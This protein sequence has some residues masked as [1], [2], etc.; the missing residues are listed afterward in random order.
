[1]AKV[2]QHDWLWI[3]SD[4]ILLLADGWSI[5]IYLKYIA[6]SLRNT[7]E[8]I[9][10]S[11]KTCLFYWSKAWRVLGYFNINF[12]RYLNLKITAPALMFE[13]LVRPQWQQDLAF[14][15]SL[16]LFISSWILFS[17][18]LSSKKTHQLVICL[19]RLIYNA[20]QIFWLQPAVQFF[21][22]GRP[23]TLLT[24]CSEDKLATSK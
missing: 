17:F 13:I 8:T 22:C 7:G 14:I 4:W 11:G 19:I 10:I 5:I 12:C 15:S 9:A 1:M 24:T 20:G 6:M 2:V 3:D 18:L 21:S 23:Q 16:I